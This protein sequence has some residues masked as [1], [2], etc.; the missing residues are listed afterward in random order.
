MP[1]ARGLF[2]SERRAWAAVVVYT[3]VLYS[4]LTLAYDLYIGVYR[5]IGEAVMSAWINRAFLAAG[6]ALL[7][8]FLPRLPRRARAYGALAAIAA[9]VAISLQLITIP[10][11]R[12]HFFQ[13]APL[14]VLAFHAIGFR[15]AGRARCAWTL[16]LVFVIG[17]GDEL[18]QG[19]L[20]TRTF[21]VADLVTNAAAGLL[22]LVFIAVVLRGDQ[23]SLPSRPPPPQ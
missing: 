1:R 20:P 13:Y 3:V 12:L 19:T 6:V 22:T 11:K 7:L 10:A 14:T 15:T 9:S 5:Q 16:G 2:S 8:L 23:H 17:L 18:I 21:G 4:T